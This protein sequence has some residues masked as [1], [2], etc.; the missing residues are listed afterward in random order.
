MRISFVSVTLKSTSPVNGT[1]T[2]I[3]VIRGLPHGLTEN[4]IDVAKRIRF[5]P[6]VK[7]GKPVS[8]RGSLEFAF[9]L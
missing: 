2:D 5:K 4:A 3:K 1:I 9:N 8:V 7:D 6:A